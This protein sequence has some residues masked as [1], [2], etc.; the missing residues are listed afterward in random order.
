[1]IEYLYVQENKENECYLYKIDKKYNKVELFSR[2][3]C[4][5]HWER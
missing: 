2:W 3:D 1:M 4:I 5:F